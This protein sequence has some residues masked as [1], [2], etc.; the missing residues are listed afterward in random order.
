MAPVL[1][2]AG[3]V[4]ATGMDT[5]TGIMTAGMQLILAGEVAGGQVGTIGANG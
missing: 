5:A 1:R 4:V 3:M 2:L